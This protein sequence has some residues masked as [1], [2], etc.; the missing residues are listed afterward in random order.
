VKDKTSHSNVH[1]STA[2]V[3]GS[4]LRNKRRDSPAGMP[5]Q[6]V[7]L[8]FLYNI[9][10]FV[11]W[12]SSFPSIRPVIHPSKFLIPEEEDDGRGGGGK[13]PVVV[14]QDKSF[15]K[16]NEDMNQV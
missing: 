11:R 14:L 12:W 7:L 1:N 4:H 6:E 13:T 10:G 16:K 2:K 8:I 15:F 9:L 3:H 5:L